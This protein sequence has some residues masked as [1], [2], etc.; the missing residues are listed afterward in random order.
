[1][2]FTY[3][4]SRHSSGPRRRFN[5]NYRLEILNSHCPF[6]LPRSQE[7]NE[8]AC[9]KQFKWFPL[10]S[11]PLRLW[12]N[13]ASDFHRLTRGWGVRVWGD[14]RLHWRVKKMDY[15]VCHTI[16]H[17]HISHIHTVTLVILISPGITGVYLWNV[18]KHRCL[19]SRSL[20]RC[21]P[22]EFLP[23]SLSCTKHLRMVNW[24]N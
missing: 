23:L 7:A 16:I 12:S 17:P 3:F 6:C 11:Q 1:M 18:R 4:I 14:D 22:T 20:V 5:N 10:Q 24:T 9:N 8:L 2:S 13:P 19:L 21:F 15:P